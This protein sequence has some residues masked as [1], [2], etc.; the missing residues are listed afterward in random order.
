[1][2]YNNLPVDPRLANWG[3]GGITPPTW[4][5]SRK[6]GIV[7]ADLSSSFAF[8]FNPGSVDFNHSMDT[9]TSADLQSAQTNDQNAATGAQV[10]ALSYAT[11]SFTILL[12]RTYEL[13]SGDR[14]L[15]NAAHQ[16]VW[17]D[18]VT[19]YQ[20]VGIIKGT[21]LSSIQPLAYWEGFLLLD[22][23]SS[24]NVGSPTLYGYLN[25]IQ[26]TL[27]HWTHDMIPIRATMSVQWSLLPN[28]TGKTGRSLQSSGT[29]NP[30]ITTPTGAIAYSY[31][32]NPVSPTWA[33]PAISGGGRVPAG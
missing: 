15:A 1:M 27:T 6:G 29:G 33:V 4:G 19:L 3:N 11:V 17:H 18:I 14:S 32:A 9:Q 30:I 25:G 2:G 22:G 13:W 31:N 24:L 23:K 26:H 10:V 5:P 8:H 7:S 21:D 12:D 20:M 16:G 28:T